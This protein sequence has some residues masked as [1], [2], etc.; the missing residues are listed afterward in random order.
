MSRKRLDLGSFQSS[1]KIDT[2]GV[3]RRLMIVAQRVKWE[4][5]KRANMALSKYSDNTRNKYKAGIVIE[6]P[7]RRG[8]R[9]VLRGRFP[10]W[11]EQGLGP[12]G[13]GSTGAF[14]I[15]RNVL[16]GKDKQVIP[17]GRTEAQVQTIV[18]RAKVS[19]PEADRISK[20]AKALTG[21]TS[22]RQPDGSHK[23]QWGGR[24]PR[25][26]V[27]KALQHHKTDLLDGM[28]RTESGYSGGQQQTGGYKVFRTMSKNGQP[29]MHPGIP[30]HRIA[31]EVESM[32]PQI[33][34]EEW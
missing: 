15:R 12:Q 18:N 28:I 30:A 21:T 33:M 17:I 14:D 3:Y 7:D 10:N 25:G 13:I 31:S 32:I 4:W 19:R 29:W 5:I 24:M 26:L 8:I 9:V 16:K 34:L 2:G 6:G 27:P 20:M 11:F 23:T 1:I 22:E